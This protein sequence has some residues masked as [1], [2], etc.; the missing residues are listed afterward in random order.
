MDELNPMY[1]NLR[2]CFVAAALLTAQC[3]V[4]LPCA[5]AEDTSPSFRPR[6]D[7]S[8][9][10]DT[11]ALREQLSKLQ[12]SLGRVSPLGDYVRRTPPSE[13][14]STDRDTQSERD[15]SLNSKTIPEKSSDARINSNHTSATKG[16]VLLDAPKLTFLQV[17]SRTNSGVSSKDSFRS[18]TL[19]SDPESRVPPTLPN[20]VIRASANTPNAGL[21]S[22][23][24]ANYQIGP[25]TPR[26]D[27]T[28]FSSGVNPGGYTGITPPPPTEIFPSAAQGSVTGNPSFAAPPPNSNLPT[29]QNPIQGSAA[30][31]YGTP[32]PGAISSPIVSPPSSPMIAPPPYPMPSA[33][34]AAPSIASPSDSNLPRYPK[35]T[36]V[37]G[38]PFVSAAPCQFDAS[39]MVSPRVYRPS[40]DP[41]AT[42]A[43]GGYAPAPYQAAPTGSP[44]HYVPP[45]AMA[46]PIRA[47][48]YPTLLRF[49][50]NLNYAYLSQGIYG[51]P[52]AYVDGQPF[53]N[54]IRYLSP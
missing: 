47:P 48:P 31:I 44:F 30:P 50:Q 11:Q 25:E 49:G 35:S 43:P 34:T 29:Y 36:T 6:L 32:L 46:V 15:P 10:R 14:S 7:P 27:A 42:S 18:T 21:P 52:K 19:V 3:L 17:P 37:N 40:L 5:Q 16:I 23:V 26:F 51:Q 28:P 12:D 54:F 8:A 2:H 4:V 45:T 33:P 39:Y 20:P 22:Y 24:I 38:P 13:S 1:L 53:R 41:C 9:A